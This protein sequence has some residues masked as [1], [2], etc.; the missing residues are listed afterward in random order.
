MTSRRVVALVLFVAVAGAAFGA[1][2]LAAGGARAAAPG[3]TLWT[4]QMSTAYGR[5]DSPEG[6]A[7]APDGSVYVLSKIRWGAGG[8]DVMLGLVKYSRG[9]VKRWQRTYR[10]SGAFSD[11]PVA[12]A[13]DREGNA[14][15]V[16]NTFTAGMVNE[17][18][19]IRYTAAG[20]RSWVRRFAGATTGSDA[21]YDVA[22][23]ANGNAVVCGRENVTATQAKF[24]VRKYGAG[25]S[26]KWTRRYGPG[27]AWSDGA[28]ALAIDRKSGRSTSAA[29]SRRPSR[30]L[31]RAPPTS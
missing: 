16:G 2:L 31:T 14:Y 19:L 24:F 5:D 25:G 11:S 22:C 26:V 30:R 8:D 27:Q 28:E 29:A 7:V 17:G 3:K 15:V 10:T 9:G 4:R 6:L 1:A 20:R 23:D 21:F 13:L 12:L 18:L